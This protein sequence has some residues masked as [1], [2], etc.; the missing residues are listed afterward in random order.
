MCRPADLVSAALP[1][2]SYAPIL[3]GRI[4]VHGRTE[5]SPVAGRSSRRSQP[6][7]TCTGSPARD[8]SRPGFT[9][10]AFRSP[11]TPRENPKIHAELCAS[12]RHEALEALRWA[13]E[14]VAGRRARPEEIAIAAAS[15]EEWDD[16]FLA[17]SDMS[18]LDLHFVHGRKVLTTP[19]G[20]LAAAP[21]R[22][23]AARLQPHAH[24]Q[25]GEP[26]AEP[27]QTPGRVAR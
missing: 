12:P 23:S 4:A 20:Q 6:R 10:S 15:P 11:E 16:H 17:L 14:L 7:L 5:M 13:R 27:G 26:V 25:A 1:R 3:F 18:G 19:D 22:G 9:S 2:T 21:R 8:T 24:G